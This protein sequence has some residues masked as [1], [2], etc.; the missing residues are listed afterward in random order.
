MGAA[1]YAQSTTASDSSPAGA[2]EWIVGYPAGGGADFVTRV[3][4]VRLGVQLKQDIDVV[5]MPGESGTFAAGTA[6]HA[7]ADGRNL[8]TADNGILVYSASLFKRATPGPGPRFRAHRL[9][10]P[11]AAA[12][13]GVAHVR[14]HALRANP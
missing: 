13:G 9:H 7:A 2:M 5:N 11:H 14:F 10:G 4:A 8:F 1:A 6:A 3:L 12:A